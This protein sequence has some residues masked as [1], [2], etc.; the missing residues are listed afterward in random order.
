MIPIVTLLELLVIWIP[1]RKV[2]TPDWYAVVFRSKRDPVIK[3]AQAFWYWPFR[4][5]IKM[6][7]KCTD[8]VTL[9]EQTMETKDGVSVTFD[10]IIET[11]VFDPVLAAIETTNLDRSI[12][13][14]AA[15]ITAHYINSLY[16]LT[17]RDELADAD[18]IDECNELA[19]KFGVEFERLSLTQFTKTRSIRLFGMPDGATE[20]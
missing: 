16:Y 20:E 18:L 9:G 11:R 3:T 17:I 4:T 1:I 14:V 15:V 2:V 6:I 10:S 13:N 7:V 12:A 5:D 19:E 8:P